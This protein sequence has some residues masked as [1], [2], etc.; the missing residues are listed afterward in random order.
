M[1]FTRKGWTMSIYYLEIEVQF[2]GTFL[3]YT[4]HVY[5][6]SQKAMNQFKKHFLENKNSSLT[7]IKSSGKADF[8]E[9]GILL[10]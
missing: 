9:N 5:F 2:E 7:W 1:S 4:Y 3:T 10:P 8:N 6:N